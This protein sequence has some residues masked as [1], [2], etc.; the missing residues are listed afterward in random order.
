MLPS[1][2]VRN[3]P[4]CLVVW[5]ARFRPCGR[6][7]LR[8]GKPETFSSWFLTPTLRRSLLW[9]RG[10]TTN[11]RVQVHSRHQ[12]R[13]IPRM[14][15]SLGLIHPWGAFGH[16]SH[17]TAISIFAE[18]ETAILR[19]QCPWGNSCMTV[20]CWCALT[21]Y[22]TVPSSNHVPE[23]D[24]SPAICSDFQRSP[25]GCT[26]CYEGSNLMSYKLSQLF[27]HLG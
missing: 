15:R 17:N 5:R 13:R 27:L 8:R 22:W 1:C 23:K 7:D 19:P 10:C 6:Y 11:R 3:L 18:L 2:H 24:L 14:L 12:N 26:I 16:S 25:W 4:R 21:L 9:G 20:P